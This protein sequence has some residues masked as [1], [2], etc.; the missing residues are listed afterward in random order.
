MKASNKKA[1]K[2]A[3]ADVFARFACL[4]LA[5]VGLG[6][7][8]SAGFCRDVPLLG[9]DQVMWDGMPCERMGWRRPYAE[10]NAASYASRKEWE[11]ETLARLKSWGFNM[12][13][14]C[15][16]SSL[17]HRGL[18]HAIFLNMSEEFCT[19]DEDR[20]ISEYKHVPNTAMPNMFHP[21][22]AA[23]CDQVARDLC[24]GNREDADLLGYY[25]DNELVEKEKKA[26]PRR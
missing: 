21:D 11:D 12:L 4:C 14:A 25:I 3:S 18:S 1:D 19:G 7:N 2:K 20:W 6:G 9:V 16:D 15:C 10:H 17:R 22:Y 23:H 24:V 5:L 13:G 26:A 8:V